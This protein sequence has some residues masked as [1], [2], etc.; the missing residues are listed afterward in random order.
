MSL[1]TQRRMHH[2]FL[3]IEQLIVMAILGLFM[4]FLIK[5]ILPFHHVFQHHLIVNKLFYAAHLAKFSALAYDKDHHISYKKSSFLIYKNDKETKKLPIDKHSIIRINNGGTLGFKGSG[6]T[7]KAGNI[8]VTT[9]NKL[10]N[11]ITLS[12]WDGPIKIN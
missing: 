10:Q 4:S 7:K 11:S 3:L 2:G 9:K 12:I 1:N 5:G 6:N 8:S